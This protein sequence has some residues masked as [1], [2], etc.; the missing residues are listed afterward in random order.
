[1]LPI[2]AMIYAFCLG[3]FFFAR[4]QYLAGLLVFLTVS[5]GGVI[6]GCYLEFRARELLKE[7]VPRTREFHPS[8][9]R[10]RKPEPAT[11]TSSN[12]P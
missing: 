2:A 3:A 5:V 7:L 6:V 12:P 10:T 9:F 11:V 1:M 4:S 8:L